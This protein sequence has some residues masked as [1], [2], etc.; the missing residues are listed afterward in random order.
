MFLKYIY[1]I[2]DSNLIYNSQK[3]EII[4]LYILSTMG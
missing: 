4:L 2:V 1:N 3:L